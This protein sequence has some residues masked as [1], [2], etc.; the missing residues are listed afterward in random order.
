MIWYFMCS[1]IESKSVTSSDLIVM[2]MHY[3]FWIMSSLD[4]YA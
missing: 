2:I 1:E 4:I 3:N